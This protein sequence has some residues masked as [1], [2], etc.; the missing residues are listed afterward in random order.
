MPPTAHKSE[1][2]ESGE[3]RI[4]SRM[5]KSHALPGA[6]CS[7]FPPR[8]LTYFDSAAKKKRY[9][10]PF[11]LPEA[12]DVRRVHHGTQLDDRYDSHDHPVLALVLVPVVA[13]Y[14]L[15]LVLVVLGASGKG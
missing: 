1:D 5:P 3:G 6:W 9:G 8:Y 12:S 10:T 11:K 7:C 4:G 14:I 15:S 2:E 13:K